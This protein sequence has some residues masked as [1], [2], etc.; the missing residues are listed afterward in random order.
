MHR[1]AWCL[2]IV[3]GLGACSSGTPTR[4]TEPWSPVATYMNPFLT[5]DNVEPIIV[6][7]LQSRHIEW[8][9]GGSLGFTLN[10]PAS[11]VDEARQLLRAEPRLQG[12]VTIL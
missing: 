4:A 5:T 3:A 11:R 6:A 9:A 8:S 10:V 12:K 1:I 7:R 2:L